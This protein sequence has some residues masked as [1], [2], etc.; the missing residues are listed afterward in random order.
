MTESSHTRTNVFAL[1]AI[2]TLS[3]V[4]MLWLFWHYP[5]S[6][7]IATIAVLTILGVSARL[8]G[9]TDSEGIFDRDRNE[10]DQGEQGISS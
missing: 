1:L 2:L 8:A 7:G 10:I 3:A 9:S 5:V 6:T 4:T